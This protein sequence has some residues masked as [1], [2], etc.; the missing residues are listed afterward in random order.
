MQTLKERVHAALEYRK[1]IAAPNEEVTQVSLAAA[2]KIKPPSVN[3]WFSGDTKSLKGDN[4]IAA[5]K[6][7][8]V[9]AQWLSS[10]VGTMLSSVAQNDSSQVAASP[11]TYI[12]SSKFIRPIWVVGKTM[13]GLPERIWTDSDFPVGELHEYAEE[14]SSDPSA[15]LCEVEGTSMMERY[16]PG[17]FALVE[18]NTPIQ[19]GDDVLVRLT[20]GETMLKRL[21]V[22]QSG[23]RLRSLNGGEQFFF[24]EPQVSWV[25]YVA[26]PVPRRRIKL[27]H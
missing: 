7:L 5:A 14:A 23:Y 27:R 8:R 11:S 12:A 19:A 3:G 22:I 18:P 20:T 17:E 13:G 1:S 15:F 2:C 4:L 21:D 6:Y 24:H 10:G 16:S 26:H 25:Y 9:N